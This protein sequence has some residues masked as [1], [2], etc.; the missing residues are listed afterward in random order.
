MSTLLAACGSSHPSASSSSTTAGSSTK[1]SG[2]ITITFWSAMSGSLGKT[3]AHL[4]DE[5]NSSQSQYKVDLIYKGSYPQTLSDTIAAFRAHKAPDIAQIF[6]AGT[7]TIMDSKGVYV[8]V[9]TLMKKYGYQFSTSDFVG[10]AAS[11]YETSSDKL[12]SEP[13]NSSTPILFYNKTELAKAGISAPPKTWSEVATDASK[14]AA[15]GTKC[16]L[17]SSGAYIMWTDIEQYAVWNDIHYATKENGY[18]GIK[19]VKLELDTKP[20]I[21]HWNLLGSLAKK[22]E[23]LWNGVSTSTVPLFTSGKCAMYEQSSADLTSIL[24]GSKFPVGVSE[25]P[26]DSSEA[27]APQNTVVGGASLWVLSGAPADT[28]KGDAEFLHFMMSSKAQAYWA[29]NTGYVAVTTAAAK[30]L[31]SEDFYKKHPSDLV[32]VDE[33]TNKPPT[34]W[35]RG[36]RLGY[37]PEIRD[38]EASAIAEI[39]S[40]KETAAQALAQAQTKSDQILQ[41]FANQYG[42]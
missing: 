37:L 33:L 23:Y 4:V 16:A 28:Y 39:L 25:L 21:D 31:K 30:L 35:T 19:G 11:Y 32:A 6:D 3:L 13:F 7:A 40:G 15:S 17:T 9:H 10:G 8:P 18:Q 29:T 36:I 22:G 38:A 41:E 34:P 20:F 26:Y 14:L 42:G 5:F 27:G 12:D 2:P 24:T 1:S